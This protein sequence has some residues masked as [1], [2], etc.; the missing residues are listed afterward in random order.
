VVSQMI[1]EEADLDECGGP[2]LD[3]LHGS[4]DDPTEA[5]VK[6]D[7]RRMVKAHETFLRDEAFAGRPAPSGEYPDDDEFEEM[8]GETTDSRLGAV[9]VVAA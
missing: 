6:A 1:R 5:K 3:Y 7:Y 4:S 8:Y 9:A 2:M